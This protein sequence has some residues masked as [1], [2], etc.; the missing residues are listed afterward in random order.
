MSKK[1]KPVNTTGDALQ[2]TLTVAMLINLVLLVAGLAA[3]ALVDSPRQDQFRLQQLAANQASVQA[4]QTNR[5]VDSLQQRL[6]TF[7]DNLDLADALDMADN[8]QLDAFRQQ[9]QQAFPEAISSRI[10]PLGARGTAAFTPVEAG[11]RNNIEIDLIRRANLNGVSMPEAYQYDSQWLISFAHAIPGRN[12]QYPSGALLLTIKRETLQQLLAASGSNGNTQLVQQF[13]TAQTIINNGT[14]SDVEAAVAPTSVPHWQIRYTPSSQTGTAL[15]TDLLPYWGILALL[16]VATLGS[17]GLALIRARKALAQSQQALLKLDTNPASYPLSGFVDIAA[18]LKTQMASMP[19]AT[20]EPSADTATPEAVTPTDL[21]EST[22][23]M[24]EEQESQVPEALT[25]TIFRAYDIRGL[26]EQQL[27][28]DVV[29]AI[30]RAIG[31]EAGQ[32]GQ[33]TVIVARDG[34]HSSERILQALTQGLCASGRDVIDIGAVPTPLLYFA[35]HMLGS[36][37]GVMVTGSHNPP[38]YNGLK[39]VIAGKTLSGDAI[40]GL[41]RRI[42][43][44]QLDEGSGNVQQQAINDSYIDHI[45]NDVAIAQPLKIVIDA[46]S[47]I[48]GAIA[49]EL[50]EQ[51]GCEVVPLFCEVDGDFPHH[52]PDPSDAANLQQLIKTVKAEQADLGIAFDGDGDRVGVVTGSGKIV[53]ADK[54]LMLLAQ[55]VVSRNPG[56]DILFDVKCTRHLNQLISNYGGRPIMWKTGHSFMKQKMQETGALL[57]GEFSGHIF[58][59]ER[60][61]GFDDGMYAAARLIEILST[62]DPD[63][64]THLEQ[65]PHIAS[66]PEIKLETSEGGKFS[67]IENLA[68]QGDFGNGKVT[69]LDGIRVDFPDSWGLIRASNTTPALILRFEGDDE[70]AL[71]KVQ[72]LFKQQ[73]KRVDDSLALDF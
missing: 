63:I 24:V 42:V 7:A 38:E 71:E 21:P 2:L 1:A 49:P 67:L 32:Q 43:Q 17:Y 50:F 69:T 73:I 29:T 26:A 16:A 60:W 31:S 41:Y 19:A 6:Q 64:E 30:G 56:V 18:K 14:G 9:L 51:L 10:V 68:K 28:D 11:I 25:E 20:P 55:D 70:Q 39:I 53:P 12:P 15:S 61:F 3:L 37:S 27:S 45:L 36:Q 13:K 44:H 57:G 8:Q 35:T 66:T 54:L 72:Q 48:T 22:L 33:Q 23:A 58:F 47:G 5:F 4:N 52:H 59:K 65:F 34:R 40:H 46:G 62:T